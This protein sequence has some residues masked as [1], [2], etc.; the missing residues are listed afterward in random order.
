MNISN[1]R[2]C[3]CCGIVFLKNTHNININPFDF[4]LFSL[5]VALSFVPSQTG[6]A[7][8]LRLKNMHREFCTDPDNL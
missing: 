8:K 5:S 2:Y 6:P 7:T 3:C 4:P 1:P